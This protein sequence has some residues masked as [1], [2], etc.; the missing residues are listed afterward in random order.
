MHLS[1]QVAL[2]TVPPLYLPVPHPYWQCHICQRLTLVCLPNLFIS[3]FMGNILLLI[4]FFPS[5]TTGWVCWGRWMSECGWPGGLDTSFFVLISCVCGSQKRSTICRK[6]RHFGCKLYGG[7][8]V[9][10]LKNYYSKWKRVL[11]GMQRTSL[12]CLSENFLWAAPS[13]ALP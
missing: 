7:R 10:V 4:V 12:R 6:K 11:P 9:P 13:L 2:S 5:K 8:E 3:N 1:A